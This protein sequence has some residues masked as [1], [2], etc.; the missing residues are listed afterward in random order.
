MVIFEENIFELMSHHD[1]VLNF[2]ES[3]SFSMVS[4]EALLMGKV[5]IATDSGGP[6]ELFENGKS[7]FLVERDIQAIK[8]KMVLVASDAELRREIG[9]EGKRVASLKFDH[10]TSAKRLK[11]IYLS[12]VTKN[13]ALTHTRNIVMPIF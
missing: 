2:S 10:I 11:E 3:E 13:A 6:K 5:L 8:S 4:L 1:V 9:I 7:G 12:Q